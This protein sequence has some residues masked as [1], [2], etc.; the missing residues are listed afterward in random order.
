MAN[1]LI[2]ETSGFPL[3]VG[4]P[5]ENPLIYNGIPLKPHWK[6]IKIIGGNIWKD[7]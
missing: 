1:W 4:S 3:V 5:T 6:K 7:M 2:A